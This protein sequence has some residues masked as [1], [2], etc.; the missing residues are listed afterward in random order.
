VLLLPLLVVM[1][2]L[3]LLVLMMM[4]MMRLRGRSAIINIL[5]S[6]RGRVVIISL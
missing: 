2:L 3:L 1:L 5:A 6:G 4:M